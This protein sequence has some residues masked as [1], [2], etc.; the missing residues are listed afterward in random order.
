MPMCSLGGQET[1]Q[2]EGRQVLGGCDPGQGLTIPTWNP[3]PPHVTVRLVAYT[4]ASASKP[5]LPSLPCLSS[6]T[7]GTP[8]FPASAQ[9]CT[10]PRSLPAWSPT[11]SPRHPSLAQTLA[12]RWTVPLITQGWMLAFPST[13]VHT[14]L[15]MT[16]PSDSSGPGDHGLEVRSSLGSRWSLADPRGRVGP[17]SAPQFSLGG[18]HPTGLSWMGPDLTLRAPCLCAGLGAAWLMAGPLSPCSHPHPGISVTLSLARTSLGPS[19][20]SCLL[21]SILAGDPKEPGQAVPWSQGPP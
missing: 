3:L 8:G 11:P 16:V 10:L 12:G 13:P 1:T 20:S 5:H 2:R 21:P 9:L 17:S 18:T 6:P 15:A 7:E 19:L 4:W 14:H